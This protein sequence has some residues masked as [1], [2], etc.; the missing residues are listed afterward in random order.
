MTTY[1]SDEP[2]WEDMHQVTPAHVPIA[3]RSQA[4]TAFAR[5]GVTVKPAEM[6]WRRSESRN[7]PRYTARVGELFTGWRL[8]TLTRR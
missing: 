5:A 1:V 4:V 8:S 3:V 6:E 7:D 2:Q